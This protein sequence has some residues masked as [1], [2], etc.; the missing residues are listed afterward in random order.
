MSPLAISVFRRRN[1]K[2]G[3]AWALFLYRD[4]GDLSC[5]TRRS[6]WYGEKSAS[7]LDRKM[8]HFCEVIVVDRHGEIKLRPFPWQLERRKTQNFMQH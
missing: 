6:S 3:L 8:F 2:A 5:A 7:T 4:G 1:Q